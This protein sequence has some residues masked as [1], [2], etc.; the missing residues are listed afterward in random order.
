MQFEQGRI[1]TSKEKG[2]L[3]AKMLFGLKLCTTEAEVD[4]WIKEQGY[5]LMM[6]KADDQ[7]INEGVNGTR[8]YPVIES[9]IENRREHIKLKEMLYAV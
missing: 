7:V 3:S 8:I 5:N 4:L 9:E 1:F 2:E 6:I